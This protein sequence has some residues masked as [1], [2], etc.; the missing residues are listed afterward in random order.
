M[1]SSCLF[2]PAND[3]LLHACL[4]SYSEMFPYVLTMKSHKLFPKNFTDF[5]YIVY[6]LVL[7]FLSVLC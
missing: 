7:W 3:I 2:L 4:L 5:S 1:T 6:Y